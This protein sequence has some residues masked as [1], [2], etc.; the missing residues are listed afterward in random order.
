MKSISTVSFVVLLLLV[1]SDLTFSCRPVLK[2]YESEG[3]GQD[4]VPIARTFKTFE[5]ENNV[6]AHGI[7]NENIYYCAEGV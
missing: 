2:L 5:E 7:K 6:T 4:Y 3:Y 1:S